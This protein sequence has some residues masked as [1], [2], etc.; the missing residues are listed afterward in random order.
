MVLTQDR[1]PLTGYDQDAFAERL[2]YDLSNAEEALQEFG[3]L[4]RANLRLL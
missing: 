3:V 4:R 1:P 2:R